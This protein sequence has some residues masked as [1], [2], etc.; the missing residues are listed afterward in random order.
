MFGKRSYP[1][2][3]FGD[4]LFL[5]RIPLNCWQEYVQ[6]RFVQTGKRIDARLVEEI[7][8]YVDGNSSYVQQLCWLVWTR[9]AVEASDEILADAKQ[10]LLKKNHALFMEQTNSLTSY[11]IRF[12]K[13]IL[14]G[15]ALEINHKSTIE[16]FGLGSSSN[17]STIKKALQKKELIE[18]N[19]KEIRFSDPI[20]EHWLRQ[21]YPTPGIEQ[22]E[23]WVNIEFRKNDSLVVKLQTDFDGKF[24][25]NL[26]KD[27]RYE[28]KIYGV[29]YF[30]MTGIVWFRNDWNMGIIYL[31]GSGGHF[32]LNENEAKQFRD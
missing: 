17:I 25:C 4:V 31:M 19:G 29:G 12:V 8:N 15:K 9:T 7:C 14:A 10:D 16:N 20:F 21:N 22:G 1:F 13:A 11:Q 2:Y 32:I 18:C 24:S 3:K 6:E 30:T 23:P 26:E 27:V 28:M 5:E